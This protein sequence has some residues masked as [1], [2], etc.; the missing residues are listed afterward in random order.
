MSW[1][2]GIWF[3][4]R[5][6]LGNWESWEVCLDI[7]MGEKGCR[8]VVMVIIFV[9]LIIVV[10]VWWICLDFFDFVFNVFDLRWWEFI[11]WLELCYYR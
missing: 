6:G 10:L 11:N 1:V 2:Y 4:L 5:F 3:F 8:K 7:I 9:R